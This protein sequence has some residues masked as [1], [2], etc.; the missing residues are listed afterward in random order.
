ML[1]LLEK[2]CEFVVCWQRM[3]VSGVAPLTPPPPPGCRLGVRLA[4]TSKPKV[5]VLGQEDQRSGFFL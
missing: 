1:R 5:E 4:T 3:V 2:Q